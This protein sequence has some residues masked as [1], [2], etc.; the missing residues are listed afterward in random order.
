MLS[1]PPIV[2]VSLTISTFY[3][4]NFIFFTVSLKVLHIIP[5]VMSL[6]F[7]DKASFVTCRFAVVLLHLTQDQ[8]V[9]VFAKWIAEH[10]SRNQ[11]HV[12]V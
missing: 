1:L 4:L 9:G 10:G 12:A 11:I 5:S 8:F 7:T 2:T 3:C 6:K